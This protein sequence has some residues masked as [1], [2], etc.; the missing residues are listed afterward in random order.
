MP[1]FATLAP[2]VLILMA[3]G[4][5]AGVLAGLLGVGGGIV[6]VPAFFY[7]FSGLGYGSSDLMQVC[8]ATSLAT[9]IVTSIRSVMAHNRKG[10]VDW[11]ILK[12]WVVPIAIGAIIGVLVV[13]QLRSSTMQIIF[14]VMVLL[15]ACYMMFGKSSWRISDGLPGGIFRAWFGPLMGFLSV[16][17]GIGGGSIGTPMQ[18]LHGIPIHRAV[19]TSAGFGVTIALPSAI[20]F[21]LTPVPDAPPYS[22]GAVNIPAFLIVI[23]MTTLTAP[24]GA[25]LAHKLDPRK[26][27]RVFAGFLM[28]VALNMLRKAFL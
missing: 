7:L 4:A 24:L 23:A 14:A 1:D 8:V 11:D 13:H 12:Q 15:I 6:L 17:L 27:K 28:L 2:L 25:A 19:A 18:T 21:L 10:A 3:V 9:I 20:G 26:L 16:L 5:F 22:I